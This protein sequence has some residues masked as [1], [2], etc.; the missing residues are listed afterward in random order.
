MGGGRSPGLAAY[1]NRVGRSLGRAGSWRG[2]WEEMGAEPDW[3]VGGRKRLTGLPQSAR[4]AAEALKQ[5]GGEE[6]RGP[7]RQL[8]ERRGHREQLQ[9]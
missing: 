7:Q 4:R 8:G 1:P 2:V 9:G 3:R 6:G 5:R